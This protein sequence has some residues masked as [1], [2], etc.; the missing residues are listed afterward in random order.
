[1]ATRTPTRVKRQ[2]SRWSSQKTESVQIALVLKS[3]EISL[4]ENTSVVA[5]VS[6]NDESQ[7]SHRHPI[8]TNDATPL[9]PSE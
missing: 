1:M 8:L 5:K 7:G 2:L 9:R 3:S 4:A 6:G